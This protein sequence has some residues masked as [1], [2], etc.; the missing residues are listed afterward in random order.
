MKKLVLALVIILVCVLNPLLAVAGNEGIQVKV[1]NELIQLDVQP[2][3]VNNRV[4]VPVRA[5]FEAL[6]IQVGWDETTKTVIGTKDELTIK[7]PIG[8]KSAIKNNRSVSLDVPA[9]INGG[10][11]LI[12]LRFIAE[13]IG[14]NVEW[15]G[16]NKIVSISME[17]EE[18]Q[19]I[20]VSDVNELIKAIGPNRKIILKNSEY[21]LSEPKK[22]YEQNRYVRWDKETDGKELIIQN[23]SNLTI[24]G[25]EKTLSNIVTES[26]YADVLIF[27]NSNNINIININAGHT[28]DKGQCS[29]GVLLFKDSDKINIVKSRL[30]GCGT[31]GLTLFNVSELLFNDSIITDCSEAIMSIYDSQNIA[32]TNSTFNENEGS[33][34]FIDLT[35]SSNI[36]FDKCNISNNKTISKEDEKSFLFY[37]D[38]SKNVVLMNSSVI[39]NDIPNYIQKISSMILEDSAF[40]DNKFDSNKISAYMYNEMGYRLQLDGDYQ[41][42]LE[43]YNK[44]ISFDP[45]NDAAHNNKGWVLV[46]LYRFEEALESCNRSIALEPNDVP[47]YINK[48][49][50]LLGLERYTEAIESYNK[51]IQLDASVK[52]SYYGK[53]KALIA[54][55][56]YEEAQASF[57]KYIQL[58]PE[59]SYAYYYLASLLAELGKY[60]EAIKNYDKSLAIEPQL[61]SSI[62]GKSRCYAMLNNLPEA[63]DNLK[64]VISFD[65]RYKNLAM[66]DEAFDRIKNTDEFRDLLKQI[67][68]SLK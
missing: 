48:G 55:G 9:T 62:Y 5:V 24:E 39:D 45:N 38:N 41:K 19:V 4:I 68:I 18:Y 59:D 10:R 3:I 66:I 54:L 40:K 49:N 43:Y 16:I 1:N 7:L 56:K 31:Q 21:N 12:P 42:A 57:Q 63:I 53:G 44:A 34:R 65:E 32:F 64:K 58:D 36:V 67:L 35:R 26:R 20:E 14:A 6:G 29:G 47:P 51:A 8:N 37:V 30:F 50:A 2:T 22:E 25:I 27:E 15:D 61:I 33:W 17:S 46:D 52:F 23:V 60:D 28:P 13:S 11:T